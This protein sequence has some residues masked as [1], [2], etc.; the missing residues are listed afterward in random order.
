MYPGYRLARYADVVLWPLTRVS[1]RQ[2]TRHRAAVPFLLLAF[3]AAV[4]ALGAVFVMAVLDR[5]TY[6]V[7]LVATPLYVVGLASCLLGDTM[8]RE[9]RYRWDAEDFPRTF[10]TREFDELVGPNR[11][12]YVGGRD[13]DAVVV[14][15]AY[16]SRDRQ[17]LDV[18]T[19]TPDQQE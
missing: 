5:P 9:W 17:E 18:V 4:G 14:R 3:V 15:M 2:P 1:R 16:Y 10:E 6:E 19:R 8:R 7:L 12:R 11:A 13:D